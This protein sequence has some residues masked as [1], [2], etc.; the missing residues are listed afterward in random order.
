[1]HDLL[2]DLLGDLL[3]HDLVVR[4]DQLLGLG[5]LLRLLHGLQRRILGRPGDLA[6]LLG[7]DRI[8]RDWLELPG[9][10]GRLALAR[11]LL[12]LLERLQRRVLGG[13]RDLGGVLARDGVPRR[14]SPQRGVSGVSSSAIVISMLHLEWLWLLRGV[15]MLWAG[16]DLELRDLLAREPVARHHPL[17]ASLMISSGR[18]ASIS[19]NVRE[20]SPPG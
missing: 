11:V 5:A 18:R 7:R 17:T 4:L 10:P 15:R 1:M 2:D 8:A 13:P 20:R 19:S 14:A 9:L 12:S 16:V 6:R 3:R